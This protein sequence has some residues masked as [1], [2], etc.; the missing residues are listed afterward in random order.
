[1]QINGNT[2]VHLYSI[3]YSPLKIMI[4]F[5]KENKQ[6]MLTSILM[7]NSNHETPIDVALKFESQ[8]TVNLLLSSLA[9]LRDGSYSRLISNKFNALF[10][11]NLVSFHEYLDS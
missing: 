3:D 1:M 11:M 5:M 8:K 9:E 10:D 6:F 7:K 2:I 4:E